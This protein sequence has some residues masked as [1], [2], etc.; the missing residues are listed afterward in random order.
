ML[1]GYV[2]GAG[3]LKGLCDELGP[4]DVAIAD[5]EMVESVCGLRHALTL[6]FIF[7]LGSFEFL[8]FEPKV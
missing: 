8:N 4:A 7:I 1:V 5:E 3:V 2:V 6:K